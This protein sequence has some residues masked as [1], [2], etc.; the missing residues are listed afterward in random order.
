MS[1]NIK[2]SDQQYQVVHAL[3]TLEKGT[4]KQVQR[5]IKQPLAHTTIAT[6]LTRMEKK[7]LLRSEVS[8]RER[9]YW[10]VISKGD[11][12]RSMVSSL[13]AT[14]FNGEPDELIAHLVQE[15]EISKA[16]IQEA[17]ALIANDKGEE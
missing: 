3:W 10:P 7:G 6:I 5:I 8:G 11:V 2:L 12:N 13:I 16:A 1:E 4:A 9:I 17:R 14:L 15:G